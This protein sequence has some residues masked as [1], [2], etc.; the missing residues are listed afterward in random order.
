MT[1]S[2]TRMWPNCLTFAT[3]STLYIYITYI[4]GLR[5][6][7]SCC[8]WVSANFIHRVKTQCSC[9]VPLLHQIIIGNQTK[10][11]LDLYSYSRHSRC[12]EVPYGV[13]GLFSSLHTELIAFRLLHRIFGK[14]TNRCLIDDSP[15][16]F[17]VNLTSRLEVPPNT[18]KSTNISRHQ[19]WNMNRL[20]WLYMWWFIRMCLHGNITCLN[21]PWIPEEWDIADQV[22][23]GWVKLPDE[24]WTK[25]DGNAMINV[26]ASP[27]NDS[28]GAT[29]VYIISGHYSYMSLI[30]MD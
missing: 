30:S 12:P 6:L 7:V 29:C 13:C 11:L 8:S 15:M 17:V 23:Y 3:F 2:I 10:Y 24:L 4:Y 27:F 28:P 21:L 9:S 22:S 18:F 1:S 20:S 26:N 16:L 19:K 25:T 5:S 14:V